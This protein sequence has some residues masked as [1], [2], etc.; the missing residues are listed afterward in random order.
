MQTC[1]CAHYIG[2]NTNLTH[3]FTLSSVKTQ[4][5]ITSGKSILQVSS[6]ASAK[7][8]LVGGFPLDSLA[9]SGFPLLICITV[10]LHT[11]SV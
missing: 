7:L 11:N 1:H 3:S 9:K 5:L 2:F 6:Y 4:T 10:F 8:S